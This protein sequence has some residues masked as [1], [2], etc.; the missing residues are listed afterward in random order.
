MP[1]Q[2]SNYLKN[3]NK[4][5]DYVSPYVKVVGNLLSNLSIA[6]NVYV[7]LNKLDDPNTT[8][9]EKP[10]VCISHSLFNT[11]SCVRTC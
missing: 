3:F 8:Q 9:K 4:V 10:V 5:I 2:L 6:R 11:K 1:G 7:N